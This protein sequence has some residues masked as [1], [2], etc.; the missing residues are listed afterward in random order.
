MHETLHRL[1]QDRTPV[2]LDGWRRLWDDLE[3]GALDRAEAMALLASLTSRLPNIETLRNLVVSLRERS[4]PMTQLLPGAVNVVGTGGGPRTFNI[5]TAAAFVAAAAGV[6]V[7]KTGSRAYTSQY[8]SVD[9]LDR[10]GIRLTSSSEQTAESLDRFG[11][12]FAGAVVYPRV[13]TQLA[14]LLVPVGMAPFGRFLNGVGPLLAAVPVTAQ[15]TG[16][17]AAGSLDQL[18]VLADDLPHEVWLVSNDAGADELLGFADNLICTN[19]GDVHRIRPGQFTAGDGGLSDLRPVARR[20]E[21][22]PHFLAV[23]AGDCGP[24]EAEAVCLN[25]AALA[26]AGGQAASWGQAVEAAYRVIRDGTARTLAEQ[27]RESAG[28]RP[29]TLEARG[30]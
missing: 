25:A 5:S 13:L 3:A 30:G 1:L 26:M 4:S 27:L 16:V 22:I 12:A 15:L 9:L 28:A 19:R 18:R 29:G 11:I 6:P 2:D 8:G 10:L 23:L 20:H 17:S 14:R 7:V 24:A 21:L